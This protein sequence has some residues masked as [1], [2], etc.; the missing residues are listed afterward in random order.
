MVKCHRLSA[1]CAHLPIFTLEGR[2]PRPSGSEAL[3][4]GL[5]FLEFVYSIVS[6]AILIFFKKTISS[7]EDLH[8]VF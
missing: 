7:L 2:N 4:H 1:L 8:N 6:F 3:F 5:P